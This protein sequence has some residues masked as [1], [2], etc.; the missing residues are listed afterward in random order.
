MVQGRETI[1]QNKRA[2]IYKQAQQI[3]YDEC[4]NIAIAHST[5]IRPAVN[6]VQNYKLHPTS[7]VRLKNV[8]MK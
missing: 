1:D 2:E 3:F 7:S 6:S 5:V 4:P 8:W